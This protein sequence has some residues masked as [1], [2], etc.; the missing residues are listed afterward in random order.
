M[1]HNKILKSIRDELTKAEFI[2]NGSKHADRLGRAFYDGEQILVYLS[3]DIFFY[4][5]DEK[6]MKMWIISCFWLLLRSLLFSIK[7]RSRPCFCVEK[8]FS[9]NQHIVVRK[10][11]RKCLKASEWERDKIYGIILHQIA[12]YCLRGKILRN[13]IFD[14]WSPHFFVC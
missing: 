11:E 13:L 7:H 1:T 4:F 8:C 6:C 12:K 2:H 5:D 10:K 3:E 9:L 14:S